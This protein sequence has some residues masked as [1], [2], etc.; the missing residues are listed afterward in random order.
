MLLADRLAVPRGTGAL[1]WDMDGV[2]LDTLT[3]DYD[4]VSRLLKTHA[5][6]EAD[7]PKAVVRAHF[8]YDLP[9]FWARVLDETG[10]ELPAETV[11]QLVHEHRKT[12][13]S[14][15]ASVHEG[16]IEI[17]EDA[18]AQDIPA[19]VVSNNPERDID[20]VLSAAGLRDYFS[21]I[22]G[23]DDP[24]VRSKPAPDP[25]LEAARRLG[26]PA[27]CAAVEDSLR[28]AQSAKAAGCW[29]IGVATGASDFGALSS[30][31]H[32]DLCYVRFA[33]CRV[34]LGRQGVTTKSLITPNEFVSHMIE[35]IAWR[36][37][38]SVDVFWTND[39]W[40]QL[41]RELG[42]SV[43]QS[44]RVRTSA[45]VLGMIDDGSCEL[46]LRASGAGGVRFRAS[47]QVDLGWF[48]GL[49]CEQ[50]SNGEPLVSL[51]QGLGA[52]CGVEFDVLV[53]SAEDPHHT[54]EGIFRAVGIGLNKLTA[55][56]VSAEPPDDTL[57]PAS[58]ESRTQRPSRTETIVERGWHVA[59]TS[60]TGASLC[61][62]TAE[63]VV[64]VGVALG[65]PSVDCQLM[66][67][68][69]VN[70]TGIA[71]LLREFAL[72]GNMRL[73][74][75]FDATRLSS[76]H[77]VAEDIGLTLGRALRCI[78]IERMVAFGVQ[79]AGSNVDS[80]DDLSEQAI[81]V[82]V[83]MEGRKFWK[84]VPFSQSYADFR[85]SF[86]VGHTLPNGLYTEDLD[87]FIDGFA[88]GLQGSVMIHAA[89]YLDP[90]TGWPLVFRGLGAA[91]RELLTRNPD[92]KALAPGVKATLA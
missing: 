5:D 81:R 78:A 25:Y 37:G 75:S 18:R 50:L 51:M 49:R 83:S 82:G 64:K 69:S 14:C 32:V 36:L 9:D 73:D 85:K 28:G 34:V 48:L 27:Q 67:S 26:S 3:M 61:R 79:G 13:E 54:W 10:I 56:L 15:A 8:P 52:G 44:P 58:G 77:V 7:V 47:R 12:R 24:M 21:V 55:S 11:A 76:S 92:R 88:G 6:I 29:T 63:S 41:G 74:V 46:A 68:D 39:D 33:P 59:H 53:A 17:L 91:M 72:A 35:H 42:Q 2:L 1:L 22:V 60:T 84:Y 40:N 31:P 86:L 30:S 80:I 4:L 38:C 62:E 87:D 16:I 20:R 89:P 45:G 19:A 65:S 57:P 43:A 66:V 70:V 71:D 90:I 23:N